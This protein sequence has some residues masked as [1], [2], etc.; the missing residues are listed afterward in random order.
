LKRRYDTYLSSRPKEAEN[1]AVALLIQLCREYHTQTHIV[2][3]S[4]SDA[5][6]PIFHARADRLPIS[7]ETCPHYLHFVAD[8]IPDGATEFRCAPPIR[9]RE[10]RELL[11]AA[12]GGHV[13]QMV[14]SDHS[15]VQISLPAMWTAASSRDYSV[16]QI[17]NLMCTAPARL[18][19]LDRKG[20]IEVGYDADL[21][22]W[23]PDLT[24]TVDP[25][26]LER[27]H[28]MTPYA[29]RRLRG[30]V[31]RTYLGG[32]RIY[33]RGVPMPRARGRLLARAAPAQARV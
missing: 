3:L 13:I 26:A 29:G 12:L 11:W 24:F 23:D 17:A 16:S 20:A 18:A 30:V 32:V 1:Q 6:A 28:P 19:G 7:V 27:R 10:N 21:A 31:L 5:L 8:E 15:P 4:S 22:I 33:E 25:A 2:H 9:E 14:V